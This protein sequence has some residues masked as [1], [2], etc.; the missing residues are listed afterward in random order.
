[1]GFGSACFASHITTPAGAIAP[2]PEGWS[3][4]AAAT[5]PTTFFTVY[6]ALKHLANLQPGERVLIHGAAG[7]VGI[8]AIQLAQHLGAEVYATAGTEEKRDFVR[9]LGV[10]HVYDS[11]TLDFAEQ[12]LADTQGEGVDVVLNSLAGE[13]IRRNL[14]VLKPFGRFL[15]LG[16]RDF[17]ENTPIGLRPFKNN[18]SFFGIDADQL[19]NGRPE[20]AKQLF[21]DV[22]ALFHEGVLYPLPHRTF[23][24]HHVVEAFRA[25]Q[26]SR[27][28]GKIVVS[29]D[30]TPHIQA[31]KSKPE[32]IQLDKDSTWLVTGG[33]SGFGLESAKWLSSRGAGHLVLINRRGMGTPGATEAIQDLQVLGASAEVV[34]CDIT[35]KA[36]LADLI[37]C[38]QNN[39]PP[40][41]GVLH[42]AAHFDD[43]LITALNTERLNA[44]LAPKVQGAWNLHELTQGLLLEHFV[45]YS[46]VTTAIGNPAQANY[47]AANAAL[48]GLARHRHAQGLPVI[49]IGWGPIADAGYLAR[50]ESVKDSLAQKLGKA[51]ITASEALNQLDWLLKTTEP[52]ITIAN[53]DWATLSRF[54]PSSTVPRFVELNKTLNG[55][56]IIQSADDIQ[57][58][59]QGKT[60][61][62]VEEIIGKR[63]LEEV[64]RILSMSPDRIEPTKPLHDLGL[65]SLMA[66]ELALGL[67]QRFK[68]QL[69]AMMLNDAP[70][71]NGL[72]V[73]IG[74]MLTGNLDDAE[75]PATQSTV[76]IETLLKQHGETINQEELAA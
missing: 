74:R 65:D 28:I 41:K 46:S 18:I 60:L 73:R 10:E 50:N 55:S 76:A 38:V 23:S 21:S 47:V 31:V 71:I 13:A 4:D 70:T 61:Q 15:E 20:L 25:M 64:S 36:A 5:V 56:A 35:D 75:L 66:V 54:L 33:A 3:F 34:A 39:C 49:A 62:E 2:M 72:S 14:Q 26:Q 63:I 40:I 16:K 42:A 1:M 37:N 43:A 29:M 51:P 45:L 19:L 11:R 67:E 68:V 22:M 32:S 58:L 12:I 57:S 30:E 8:A 53:V 24:A 59:I 27:H 6:Y 9:M 69:P 7:G 48:E 52:Q 17:F 44:V